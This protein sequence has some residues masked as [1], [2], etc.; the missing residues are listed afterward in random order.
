MNSMADNG[1]VLLETVPDTEEL[2]SY[3]MSNLIEHTGFKHVPSS[4]WSLEGSYT[5]YLRPPNQDIHQTPATDSFEDHPIASRTFVVFPPIRRMSLLGFGSVFPVE[6]INSRD[7][8]T[9]H[10][11][12]QYMASW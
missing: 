12:L 5:A 11:L 2:S 7:G 6:G 3:E 9:M 10:D 8:V 4:S 1:H